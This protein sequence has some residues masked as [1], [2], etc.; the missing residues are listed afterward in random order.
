MLLGSLPLLPASIFRAY[1][2]RGVV[3][4][5]LTSEGVFLIGKALGSLVRDSGEKQ[6][7]VARDGRFSGTEL[8][9][10]LC[11]GILSVGCDVV[12]LGM[13]PTP[14]LYYATHVFD[15][16]SGVMLTGS[17][18]PPEYNGLK[19]VVKGE[20]LA[21]EAIQGLYQ[22]IIEK[23]FYRGRSGTR[24]ELN[25]VECYINH[26]CSNVHLTRPLKI[27][28]DA[29]NGV[30]GIMAPALF[31]TL[32]CEVHELF[33]EVDGSFPNHHADPSQVENLQDLIQKVRETKS[34]IGLAFDGDGDR[35]GVVTS[36]GNIIWPDRLLM[37]Y[38][39]ALLTSSPRAKIIYDVKCTTHLDKRIRDL[40]GE[41]VMWKTGHSLI[42]A[43]M[44]EIKAQL[45][46]EM[47][48]HFFF[49]DRWN[50]YDDALYAGARL[51]EI[52]S[53]QQQDSDTLFLAIPNS[54]NT[55]ELKIFINEE[56][57]FGLMQQLID[58]A[59]FPEASDVITIDGLRVNFSEGW[60]LVRPSNTSPY[61]VLRFE[62]INQLILEK[63]QLLFKEWLLAVK[64][65]LV[66]PF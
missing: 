32:G 26:V 28:I 50:G 9:K 4:K 36:Q 33:C 18:N 6:I 20:T 16:H 22:R 44:R 17:H 63:I 53:Q 58:Q 38:A 13:I 49:K 3:G 48:G 30:A 62:A 61:L 24:Y 40:D 21:E 65:D 64:P 14:L 56:E 31:R 23:R 60:G 7:A 45:A 41:P 10:S 66:L 43:K 57:K 34:D 59:N 2:I 37:L 19:M 52:L 51:L 27:V 54:V 8:A 29:G 5:T 25:I 42:K 11:D 39:E 35:L 12:D 55:P 1:D 15:E 47:S 46:G